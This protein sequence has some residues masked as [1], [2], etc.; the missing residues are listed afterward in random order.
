MKR[1]G[2]GRDTARQVLFTPPTA[3]PRRNLMQHLDPTTTEQLV[4]GILRGGDDMA[5]TAATT[6]AGDDTQ[7]ED[8]DT[9]ATTKGATV[10]TLLQAQQNIAIEQS[11]DAALV[12]DLKKQGGVKPTDYTYTPFR[13]YIVSACPRRP[14]YS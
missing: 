9:A 6:I 5:A 1:Y 11:D 4:R 7:G 10:P 2:S 3:T 14:P 8:D 13:E 12:L